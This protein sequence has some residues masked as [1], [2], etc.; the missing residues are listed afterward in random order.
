MEEIESEAEKIRELIPTASVGILHG[1]MSE[2]DI[3]ETLVDFYS[4]KFDITSGSV[5]Q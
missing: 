2:D 4:K 3:E 1:Q 5:L